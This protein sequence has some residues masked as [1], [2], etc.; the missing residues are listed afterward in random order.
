M[1]LYINNE[2]CTSIAQLKG[3]FSGSLSIGS[4]IFYDLLDR[5]RY[6][7]IAQWLR[8][9]G[10]DSIAERVESINPELTDSEYINHLGVAITGQS[11]KSYAKPTFAKCVNLSI[12]KKQSKYDSFIIELAFVVLVAVNEKYEV[13]LNTGWGTKGF[14]L[15]PS[16]FE[17]SKTYQTS[18]S[19]HKRPGR[20]IKEIIISV[21]EHQLFSETID[22]SVKTTP[23]PHLPVV[24]DSDSAQNEVL[25]STML[26]LANIINRKLQ[27]IEFTKEIDSNESTINIG[28]KKDSHQITS[29]PMKYSWQTPEFYAI[30]EKD[31]KERMERE[32]KRKNHIK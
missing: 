30:I 3:Y 14:M 17:E 7:D 23:S 11:I 5:G 2:H 18:F 28:D 26:R 20:D 25:S 8:E 15:N 31:K 4:I 1:I 19:F 16:E 13:K 24:F 6:G 9:I 12:S 27:R 32:R 21:D 22:K 10:E 29:S